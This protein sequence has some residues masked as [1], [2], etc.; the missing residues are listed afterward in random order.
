MDAATRSLVWQR[1]ESRCEY[2][3]LH[4]DDVPIPTFHVEHIIPKKHGGDDSTSNLCLSCSW[5]NLHKSSNLS[6]IDDETNDIVQLFHPRTQR[7]HEH[8][9]LKRHRIVGLTP[10]GRATVRV[11]NMNGE[12]RLRLRRE[13]SQIGKP[14]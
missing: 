12:E 1:A 13:L 8:F 5:C 7:W 11:M 10:T 4:Q 9:A 6:G 14:E 2:C 3:Q